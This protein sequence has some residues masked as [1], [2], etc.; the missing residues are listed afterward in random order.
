MNSW[1]PVRRP[2]WP[3]SPAYSPF[4]SWADFLL[5]KLLNYNSSHY[6]SLLPCA[7]N[8]FPRMQRF[9]AYAIKINSTINIFLKD[10]VFIMQSKD[11]LVSLMIDWKD[12]IL[13]L[14][15]IGKRSGEHNMAIAGHTIHF[16]LVYVF[17][18]LLE[19]NLIY[20][21]SCHTT[22]KPVGVITGKMEE[23]GKTGSRKWKYSLMFLFFEAPV[24]MLFL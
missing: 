24:H 12:N 2:G 7:T 17:Y 10:I 18:I 9:V 21:C 3:W 15:L 6:L 14:C 4:D 20:P 16:Y 22:D 11:S 19:L 8:F 1:K 13:I 23:Q 5:C